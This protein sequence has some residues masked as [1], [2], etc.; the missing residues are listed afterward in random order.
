MSSLW[1]QLRYEWKMLLRSPVSWIGLALVCWFFLL[2][3]LNYSLNADTNFGDAANN[4][5]FVLFFFCFAAMLVAVD[6]GRREKIENTGP[7]RYTMPYVGFRFLVVKWLALIIPFTLL[8]WFP[9]FIY[10]V[11]WFPHLLEPGAPVGLVYLASFAIPMWFV[12][13]A[14][15]TIGE[16]IQSRWSYVLAILI[17]IVFVYGI[18]IVL[19]GRLNSPFHL[20]NLLAH[21]SI[22]DLEHYSLFWGFEVD[23]LVWLHRLV[24][25]GLT[26]ALAMWAGY[27]Y[28]QRRRE[29]SAAV[30]AR[31]GVAAVAVVIGAASLYVAEAARQRSSAVQTSSAV[32]VL[33]SPLQEASRSHAPLPSSYR[34]Q[35]TV[36][37][38]GKLIM[39]VQIRMSAPE[40]PLASGETLSF[41]LDRAFPAIAVDVNGEQAKWSRVDDTDQVSIQLPDRIE[42]DF[43]I[44]F[45]YEGTIAKWMVGENSY[46]LPKVKR[47]SFSNSTHVRL[48]ED[49]YW[50]PVTSIQIEE[51]RRSQKER[52]D[53]KESFAAA[54]LGP[55]VAYDIEITG[56]TGMNMLA[57][58]MMDRNEDIRGDRKTTLLK[59]QS[60][61]PVMLIGGPF[62]VAQA[63]GNRTH[64]TFVAS[65]LFQKE[66]AEETAQHTVRMLER[67]A[68]FI[69]S[70][71]SQ[72]GLSFAFPERIVIVP[73]QSFVYPGIYVNKMIE[74]LLALNTKEHFESGWLHMNDRFPVNSLSYSH[75]LLWLFMEQSGNNRTLEA[76]MDLFYRMLRE[77]VLADPAAEKP[78]SERGRFQWLYETIGKE[79]FETFVWAFYRFLQELDAQTERQMNSTTEERLEISRELSKTINDYITG[80]RKG[81]LP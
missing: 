21:M 66:S 38:S 54:P 18:Q 77:Y 20:L 75:L 78:F 50:Y 36:G 12:V 80:W 22:T 63:Q 32:Q 19:L 43:L 59:G 53:G 39:L 17:C 56:P 47:H 70:T 57:S 58:K 2:Y 52:E 27:L 30:C 61:T 42:N 79:R 64:V 69:E 8:S 28:G 29:R 65:S 71:S 24:Y 4:S 5:V 34:I 74:D 81:E 68:E 62:H 23:R 72:H 1:L 6:S 40:R 55:P 45:K 10:S 46:G 13:I 31:L 33:V 3:F 16:R 73:N 15:F 35:M 37:S 7:L 25:A 49:T 67:A 51:W 14:G 41:F 48:P 9:F 11:G 26:L 76:P 44:G 60:R